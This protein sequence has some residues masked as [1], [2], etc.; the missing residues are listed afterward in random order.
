MH[1]DQYLLALERAV[2]A[3][4][5]HYG[6]VSQDSAEG[7]QYNFQEYLD[8]HLEEVCEDYEELNDGDY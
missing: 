8:V 2:E 6:E 7:F 1:I 3:L 4:R 5:E